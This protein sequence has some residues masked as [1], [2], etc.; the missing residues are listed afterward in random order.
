MSQLALFGGAP[1]RATPFP[2][3]PVFDA[4]EEAAVLDVVRSGKWWRYSQGDLSGESRVAVFQDAFARA[5]GAK[6]GIACA[7]GTAALDIA[8]KAAG[9]GPGDEVIVPPYTFVATATAPLSVNAVPIFCDIDYDTFNLDPAKLAEAI[10]PRTKAVIPVHFA[11][12]AADM[13]GILAV[14]RRHGLFV[15]EDAAH[16]HGASWNHR[17]LGTIGGAGT[18]SF[19]ASKNM[20]AGEGG[21]IITNDRELANGVNPICGLD[22]KSGVP[23][24]NII[25][26]VGI[27]GSRS[28]RPL[29]S[30]SS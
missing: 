16:A 5:Q 3:W 29:F 6:F 30:S 17:G 23:G 4:S 27:T 21:L 1:V 11:G 13:D 12:M 10:T 19:Q 15:L 14:A 26:S 7:S 2:S 18:F 8:L 24:M 20:T 25:A 9:I 28:F 22:G